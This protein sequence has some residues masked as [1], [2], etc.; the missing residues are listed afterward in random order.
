MV[1]SFN[2]I[3]GVQPARDR[4]FERSIFYYGASSTMATNSTGI[5]WVASP[6][7]LLSAASTSNHIQNRSTSPDFI[8]VHFVCTAAASSFMIQ[9][10]N[11]DT[12]AL[13]Q[14]LT[15]STAVLLANQQYRFVVPIGP[16]EEITF[17]PT[18]MSSG[19]YFS[20]YTM[21]SYGAELV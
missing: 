5:N 10:W 20:L 17:K 16:R 19:S 2:Q 9:K 7:L 11:I 21:Q 4:A 13:T 1:V 3:W 14:T 18:T 8:A 12:T 6:D 15:I